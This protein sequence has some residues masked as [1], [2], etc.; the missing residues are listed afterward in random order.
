M[1]LAALDAQLQK[2]GFYFYPANPYF[3]TAPYVP[4]GTNTAVKNWLT[5]S[6]PA[7]G[8]PNMGAAFNYNLIIHDPGAYAHNRYYI[9]RLIYD[10]IDWLD[11]NNLNSSVSATLNALPDST[12]YKQ[13]AI[14]YLLGTTGQRP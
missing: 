6:D 3:Y 4:G 9:K 8:K 1:P 10:S 2:R 12:T 13:N 14:T 7:T 11:D 5:N